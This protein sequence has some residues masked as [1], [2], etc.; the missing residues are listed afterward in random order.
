[1]NRTK[2]E[3]IKKV[4]NVNGWTLRENRN[5]FP[6]CVYVFDGNK[7]PIIVHNK[8]YEEEGGEMVRHMRFIDQKIEKTFGFNEQTID[9]L[10]KKLVEY[11]FKLDIEKSI[12]GNFGPLITWGTTSNIN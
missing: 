11:R 7:N 3:I 8:K 6:T 2:I 4:L 9:K 5:R 12:V 10:I 1:M